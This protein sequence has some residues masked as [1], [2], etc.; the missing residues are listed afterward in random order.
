M[1]KHSRA[2]YTTS[3]SLSGLL[4]Q[5]VADLSAYL[6]LS[7]EME[8]QKALLLA[9]KEVEKALSTLQHFLGEAET[10]ANTKFTE[11]AALRQCVAVFEKNA[12]APGTSS[13]L[14]K[15]NAMLKFFKSERKCRRTNKRLAYFA[16]HRSRMSP[17]IC[18]IIDRSRSII[19]DIMGN[20]GYLNFLK[21]VEGSGFGPGATFS[22]TDPVHKHLY[23]K[24]SGPHSCTREALPYLKVWLN[25]WPHW[26]SSL[27]SESARYMISE[28][29]RITTVPKSSEVDRTIAIEPSLN[30][31]M[32]K[33]VDSYL[34]K[35]L[36]RHGVDLS[37]QSANH[38]P[39]KLGSMRPLYAAT[40]DLSSAS[41]CVS[42]E[43]VRMLLPVDWF[44]LL[45]DLRSKSYTLDKGASWNRYEKFSSMGNAF[46]F[47]LETIIF[48]SVAKAC[49]MICGEEMRC[50]KVYGDDI[51]VP[52]QAYCL[53]I[54]ALRFLGFSP[55]IDK[56]FAFGGFRETCG[57][58]FYSGVDLR[59]VYMKVVPKSDQEVYNLFN[60][61]VWNRVGFKF[62]RTCAYLYESVRRPFIGPPILPPK[63]KFERW[64][65]GK[66]LVYDHYFHADPDLGI[67]FRRY[68][69]DW[70]CH[71]YVF[72]SLRLIPQKL[73]TSKW[74]NQFWYLAFLLGIPGDRVDSNSRFRYKLVKEETSFWPSMPW[75]PHFFDSL[76]VNGPMTL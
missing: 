37:D 22:S 39:A 74:R 14:R 30:V 15:Q 64:Y 49:T 56:S 18:E 7:C 51:I 35:R 65:S 13:E 29:N 67:R 61:L 50:L 38:L 48:Y 58:D 1:P 6:P 36:R 59:P 34:K 23:H 55:N 45:D 52:P 31:F 69:K 12:D 4:S 9:P 32:Q 17:D 2:H 60:R 76:L 46:T 47:P 53:L 28:G 25:H 41:D 21:I 16:G 26:K 33:G 20:L 71:T 27:I 3:V 70:Q 75:R 42:I 10:N 73:E 11:L 62:H 40:L 19:S 43:V 8:V 24:V 57:S 68:N 66:S 63:E 44:T 54:E 72:S 5:V